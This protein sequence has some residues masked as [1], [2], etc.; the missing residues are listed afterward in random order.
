MRRSHS[1]AAAFAVAALSALPCAAFVQP[2]AGSV[3]PDFDVRRGGEIRTADSGAESLDTAKWAEGDKYRP[4]SGQLEALGRLRATVSPRLRV[5]FQDTNG[6]PRQLHAWGLP[7][8]PAS[9]SDRVAIARAYLKANRDLF[10]LSDAEV[11]AL[12]VARDYG[13]HDVFHT[14]WLAQSVDGILVDQSGL[15]FGFDKDRRMVWVGVD[16]GVV[17]GL[18]VDTTAMISPE[19]AIVAAARH[20][21]VGL[22]NVPARRSG[23]GARRLVYDS[24]P[25]FLSD[26]MVE[27]IILAMGEGQAQLTW[28]V[29]LEPA[30]DYAAWYVVTVDT[31]AGR[32]LKRSN[33][34]KYVDNRGLVFAG[35]HP[36]TASPATHPMG[37]PQSVESYGY[38]WPSTTGWTVPAP[39]GN[40]RFTAGNNVEAREDWAGDNEAAPLGMWPDGGVLQDFS[41]TFTNAYAL[42]T[43]TTDAARINDGSV[44][45]NAVI[46]NLFYWNNRW[47]DY[48]YTLGFTEAA[49]NFQFDNFSR[50][51][52][53][54]DAVRADA[55][56]RAKPL[57]GAIARNNANFGTPAEPIPTDCADPMVRGTFRPRMQ[58]YVS[59]FGTE[60]A[61]TWLADTSLDADVIIHEYSHGTSHRLVGGPFQGCLDLLQSGAMGEG[62]GDWYAASSFSNPVMGEYSFADPIAGVREFPMNANP[63]TYADVCDTGCQVHHDGEVFAATAWDMRTLV[64]QSVAEQLVTDGMKFSVCSPDFLDYRDALVIAD[65]VRYGGAHVCNIWDAYFGRGMGI[66]ADS[67]GGAMPIADFQFNAPVCSGLPHL[68]FDSYSTSDLAGGNGDGLYLVG[69]TIDLNVVLNNF[70]GVSTATGVTATVTTTSPGITMVAGTRPYPN[71]AAGGSAGP[72]TP[73]Q[74]RVDPGFVC[75]TEI[76][77]QVSIGWAPSFVRS[78]AFTDTSG[79]VTGVT[80]FTHDVEGAPLTLSGAAAVSTA[81]AHGGVNSYYLSAGCFAG[82]SPTCVPGPCSNACSSITLPAMTLPAGQIAEISFWSTYNNEPGWDGVYVEA[83]TDGGLSFDYVA[84]VNYPGDIAGTADGC[85]PPGFPGVSG[86]NPAGGLVPWTQFVGKLLGYEGQTVLLRLTEHHDACV[87]F[88]GTWIDDISVSVSSC[89][90][91]PYVDAF[92][93]TKVNLDSANATCTD[94]DSQPDPGEIVDVTLAV[95]NTG[96]AMASNMTGTLSTT[97]LNVLV[98]GPTSTQSF[99]N[100][101]PGQAVSRTFRYTVSNPGPI[102]FEPADFNLALTANAGAYTGSAQFTEILRVNPPGPANVWFDDMEGTQPA[103]TPSLGPSGTQQD[104]VLREM[105]CWTS[106]GNTRFFWSTNLAMTPAT[107]GSGE[108][109]YGPDSDSLLTS[110]PIDLGG[111]GARIKELSWRLVPE[112]STFVANWGATVGSGFIEV[113]VDHDGDGTFTPLVNWPGGR[114]PNGL[115][116]V[117]DVQNNELGN[118]ILPQDTVQMV[119]FQFRL[120]ATGA[121]ASSGRDADG[122]VVD[123]FRVEWEPCDVN[124]C[125]PGF[126][127]G[128]RSGTTSGGSGSGVS[129]SHGNGGVGGGSTEP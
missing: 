85:G 63:R 92:L 51:G 19:D 93:S 91:A 53:G 126:A 116:H 56:D 75:G 64:G 47:H 65:Q 9:T 23:S 70:I 112:G 30:A 36:D 76:D 5:R 100:V 110:P 125:A 45:V 7:M 129:T 1:F 81:E 44:D 16:A 84:T 49:G 31:R 41:Y 2:P 105:D 27:P 61:P 25:S 11:D 94:L 20:I 6:M 95:T 38:R 78:D 3:L 108:P 124:A 14:V 58:Q 28:R 35:N 42:S 55:Q 29:T 22:E 98:D 59:R 80:L 102:C 109:D 39:Y 113:L 18:S 74:F 62:W 111:P 15:R 8:T 4:T 90:T 34:Y 97:S 33:L 77:F 72:I 115:Y 50:G 117:L 119:R 83:S 67:I 106:T 26:I 89:R 68:L 71:I 73:F 127:G 114:N 32:L 60:A 88:E 24:G 40:Y 54:S 48:M 66:D 43:G 12:V 96:N 37:V 128:H 99:G 52:C 46:N 103:W 13:T 121:D 69:E 104:F 118:P 82:V 122:I 107:C 86:I 79:A 101:A 17:P 87:E 57:T 21:G 10:R 120:R 123:N